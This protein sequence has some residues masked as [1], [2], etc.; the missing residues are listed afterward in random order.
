MIQLVPVLSLVVAILAVFVG[1][2]IS[3]AIA[4]RQLEASQRIASQQLIGP[5][6][7]AWINE[8]RKAVAE[9]LSSG[10]HYFVAGFE[11]RTDQEYRRLTELEHEVIL[12]LNPREED[13]MALLGAIRNMIAALEGGKQHDQQFAEEHKRTAELARR[14]LKAE[15]NRVKE[16]T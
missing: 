5:M 10:L 11:D 4:R 6:R 14:V 12:M 9:L 3:W 1:P 16:G 8:L 7:Q 13:H 2:M 15:W